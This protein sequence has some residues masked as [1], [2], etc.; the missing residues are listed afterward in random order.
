[1][2]CLLFGRSR[3]KTLHSATCNRCLGCLLALFVSKARRFEIF[4]RRSIG[5]YPPSRQLRAPSLFDSMQGLTGVATLFVVLQLLIGWR[6]ARQVFT[7]LGHRAPL[8]AHELP[9]GTPCTLS[10]TLQKFQGLIPDLNL[11]SYA[12]NIR[13]AFNDAILSTDIGPR[14]RDGNDIPKASDHDLLDLPFFHHPIS[15]P[16]QQK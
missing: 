4:V 10:T 1:M 9:F 13:T 3:F 8:V 11:E 16:S 14:N 15:R 12:N 7:D 5:E 2:V 6:L